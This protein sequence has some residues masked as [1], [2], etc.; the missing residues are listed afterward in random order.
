MILR[1][2]VCVVF[3]TLLV[4]PAVAQAVEDEMGV[5]ER[6][7]ERIAQ[8]MVEKV[9]Q[10]FST[11]RY[12]TFDMMAD[13]ENPLFQD[14]N[15][16][17]FIMNA[18]GTFLTHTAAP[19]LIGTSMC[20]LNNMESRGMGDFVWNGGSSYGQWVSH[21]CTY[22]EYLGPIKT[23]IRSGWGHHF[24]ASI[25]IEEDNRLEI[26]MTERDRERQAMAQAM[27]EK[28]ITSFMNNPEQ[29][30][31][32]IHDPNNRLFY[33]EEL[34]V[35]IIHNNS[36]IIAHGGVPVLAGSSIDTLN[37]YQ[38]ANLGDIYEEGESVYGR[39]I[40]YQWE[41][42]RQSTGD[43]LKLTWTKK[44]GDH[45]FAV[46]I[47]PEDPENDQYDMY[48]VHDATR[49]NA[50][51]EM[52]QMAIQT[53]GEDVE[54]ATTLI[55][56]LD[57]LF[58]DAELSIVIAGPNGRVVAHGGSPNIVGAHIKDVEYSS[59]VT[60]EDIFK[61][62]SPYG[63]WVEH[64]GIHPESGRVVIQNTLVTYAGGHTFAVGT[65]PEYKIDLWPG[66]T[67]EEMVQMQVAQNMVE[68]TAEE[69]F[70]H[71]QATLAAIHDSKNSPF[72]EDDLFVVVI[73]TN[74]TIVGHGYDKWIVGTDIDNLLDS[75][76]T[77]IGNIIWDNT[78]AYGMWVEYYWPK[79]TDISG[80]G[81]PQLVWYKLYGDYLFGAGIY[82]ES[83]R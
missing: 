30:V 64:M 71:P 6:N 54:W 14:G 82:P 38:G 5:Y 42:P 65:Y 13:P 33:N 4:L 7:N 81:N 76:G 16:Y 25:H 19:S 29:T 62:G 37:D 56:A 79:P 52:T 24:G 10:A 17:S 12:N 72:K 50:A 60:L 23:W 80:E 78:S 47:Y 27:V 20:D 57:P 63:N 83:L 67:Q 1:F 74:G 44:S 21:L 28:T 43:N 39:W 69:F 61:K 66:L 51:V 11:D 59:G 49:K 77:N 34:F 31:S 15:V 55:H 2:W 46:G 3:A 36:T 26:H 22:P 68:R 40:E 70:V 58:H 73:H 48:S 41:D 32:M 35:E 8:A 9:I 18:D 53:Y 45:I 75:R